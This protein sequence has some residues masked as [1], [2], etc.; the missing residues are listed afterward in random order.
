MIRIDWDFGM[1]NGDLTWFKQKQGSKHQQILL[2]FAIEKWSF[3]LSLGVK[4]P[5]ISRRRFFRQSFAKNIG[6]TALVK[7]KL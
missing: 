5:K 7:K 4:K 3:V 2:S 1:G 6:K